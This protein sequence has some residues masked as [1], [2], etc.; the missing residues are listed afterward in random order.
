MAIDWEV[1]VSGLNEDFSNN[2]CSMQLNGISLNSRVCGTVERK[3][4]GAV[5]TV[6]SIIGAYR[7][8]AKRFRNYANRTSVHRLYSDIGSKVVS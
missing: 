4:H 2:G 5:H 6:F 1:V 8:R 7:D 3:D